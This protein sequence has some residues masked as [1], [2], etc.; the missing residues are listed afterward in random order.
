MKVDLINLDEIRKMIDNEVSQQTM[1]N[2]FDYI[3]FKYFYIEKINNKFILRTHKE[4]NIIN[5]G[6]LYSSFL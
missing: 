3:P 1:K 4:Y 5:L 2:F 6:L